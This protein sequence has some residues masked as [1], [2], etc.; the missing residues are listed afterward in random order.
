M[1]TYTI[2]FQCQVAQTYREKVGISQFDVR[3]F[4]VS[5]LNTPDLKASEGI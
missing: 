3:V 2:F 4:H 5:A 1:Y